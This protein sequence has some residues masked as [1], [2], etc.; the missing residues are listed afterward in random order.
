MVSNSFKTGGLVS[1]T[2]T[3]THIGLYNIDEK[4]ASGSK[5]KKGI[6]FLLS[7]GH[8]DGDKSSGSVYNKVF[9]SKEIRLFSKKYA[10]VPCSPPKAQPHLPNS[11]L[12]GG[13][14]C[15]KMVDLL[16]WGGCGRSSRRCRVGVEAQYRYQDSKLLAPVACFAELILTAN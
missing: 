16:L 1:W 12:Q 4:S 13:I 7:F 2:F 9:S 10:I 6:D 11:C 8:L 3:H 15:M 5:W 14:L